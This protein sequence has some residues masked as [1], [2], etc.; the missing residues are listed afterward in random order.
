MRNKSLNPF[1]NAKRIVAAGADAYT[2]ASKSARAP[3]KPVANPKA[4]LKSNEAGMAK[5]KAAEAAGRA[6][7]ATARK[8]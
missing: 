7:Q 1:T 8:K 6:R 3:A 2:A 5:L 4:A